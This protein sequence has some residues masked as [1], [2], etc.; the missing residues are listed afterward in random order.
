MKNNNKY[1]VGDVLYTEEELL[2]MIQFYNQYSH[3]HQ[4][5]KTYNNGITDN[6]DVDLQILHKSNYVYNI[7]QSNKHLYSL[8]MNDD[9]I[10]KKFFKEQLINNI[11]YHIPNG[12][13]YFTPIL[14][15]NNS[16]EFSEKIF[17]NVSGDHMVELSMG[18]ARESFQILKKNNVYYV[19]EYHKTPILMNQERLFNYLNQKFSQH[20]FTLYYDYNTK[21]YTYDFRF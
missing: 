20:Q 19:T 15:S 14:K 8:C 3:Y 13:I 10:R 4:H 17:W 16:D 21:N 9:I 12:Y 11:L 2:T 18:L 1:I 6:N 5:P 7:C